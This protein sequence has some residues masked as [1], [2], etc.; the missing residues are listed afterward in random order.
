MKAVSIL[1]SLLG[2]M[3]ALCVAPY[4]INIL[5]TESPDVAWAD[6]GFNV[7]T[8]SIILAPLFIIGAILALAAVSSQPGPARNT[9]RLAI[10]SAGA[11]CGGLER[12]LC[13]LG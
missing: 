12:V 11:D 8:Y 6:L 1:F 7:A 13:T 10:L 5:V 2:L 3:N 4:L 9:K